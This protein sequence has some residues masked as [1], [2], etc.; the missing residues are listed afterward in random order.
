MPARS[1]SAPLKLDAD[2]PSRAPYPFPSW[3]TLASVPVTFTTAHGILSVSLATQS[4]QDLLIHGGSSSLGLALL[5]LARTP[6]FNLS[7]IVGTTRDETKREVLLK[8]GFD[9][10][11]VAPERKEQD[12]D[13]S[14]AIRAIKANDREGF[15]N[16]VELI[17]TTNLAVSL[18]CAKQPGGKVCSAGGL[19][20]GWTL[21]NW[22]LANIVRC[23][24]S[25]AQ[26]RIEGKYSRLACRS[27]DTRATCTTATTTACPSL[28]TLSFLVILIPVSIVSSPSKSCRRRIGTWTPIR[29]VPVF[30]FFRF[31]Y[32][33]QAC[34]KIVCV[35]GEGA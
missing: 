24:L 8:G 31:T 9:E 22:S 23:H 13:A 6:S 20:H 2:M 4:G 15:D 18:Q 28:S 25:H 5:H 17:G 21:D 1:L 16:S 7:R 3:S 14:A 30:L 26:Q 34:G 12:E 32:V 19:A 35:V 10:V 27:V 29:S 33:V 11:I